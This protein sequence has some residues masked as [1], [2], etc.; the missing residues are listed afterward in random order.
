MGLQALRPESNPNDPPVGFLRSFPSIV[1]ALFFLWP[2]VPLLASH[3]FPPQTHS[4]SKSSARVSLPPSASNG[5]PGRPWAN[6]SVL[7]ASPCNGEGEGDS[8]VTFALFL[9]GLSPFEERWLPSSCLLYS[10]ELL[11]VSE[12][13]FCMAEQLASVWLA[14]AASPMSHDLTSVPFF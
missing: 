9:R 14:V 3:L 2:E 10:S 1:C 12:Y 5:Q 13:T 4:G 6:P 8:V 7:Q 11:C